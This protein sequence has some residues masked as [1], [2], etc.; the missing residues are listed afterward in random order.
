MNFLDARLPSRFWDKVTPE[1]MS[2]CWLW[3]GATDKHG[4][5][6]FRL[7]GTQQGHRLTFAV[8]NDVDPLLVLDHRCSTPSCVNPSHLRQVTQEANA[9]RN[10]RSTRTHCAAG[11]EFNESNTYRTRDGRGRKCRRC[12]ADKQAARKAFN[13]RGSK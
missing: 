4:Y 1:P 10:Y 13:A 9:Q 8:E 5:S 3:L 7:I 12:H 6:R 11:H 2:G